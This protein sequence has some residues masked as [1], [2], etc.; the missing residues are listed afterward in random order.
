[1]DNIG[2]YEFIIYFVGIIQMVYFFDKIM[3]P[4]SNKA[5]YKYIYFIVLSLL[6]YNFFTYYSLN[7]IYSLNYNRNVFT[8]VLLNNI[9]ILSYPV[10]LAWKYSREIIFRII[11]YLYVNITIVINA[12]IIFCYLR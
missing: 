6:Y 1:M 2:S 5:T 3:S 7:A 9:M 12:F 11:L 4:K 8:L 10:F